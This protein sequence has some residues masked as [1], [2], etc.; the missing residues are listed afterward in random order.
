MTRAEHITKVNKQ[1]AD[2]KRQ[3][4]RVAV[5]GLKFLQLP[6]SVRSVA[7]QAGVSNNTAR[8][9]LAELRAEGRL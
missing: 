3:R 7:S 2:E 9:Y 6:V 8:K 4:V 1:R 5:E